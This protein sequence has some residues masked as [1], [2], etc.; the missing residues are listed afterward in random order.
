MMKFF[1]AHHKDFD[2][3]NRVTGQLYAD[4]ENR[5]YLFK[6]QDKWHISDTLGPRLLVDD[7]SWSTQYYTKNNRNYWGGYLW[8]TGSEYVISSK[9]GFGVSEEWVRVYDDDDNYLPD[10]SYWSGDAWW[11]CSTLEG[12]YIPRGRHRD[13]TGMD[14]TVALEPITGHRSDTLLGVYQELDE[15]GEVNPSGSTITIGLPM[16]IDQNSGVYIRSKTKNSNG[17][18]HYDSIHHDGEG[19][20][21]GARDSVNGWW[22]GNE[23]NVLSAVTF[24]FHKL[25]D[26]EIEDQ[27]NLTIT[28]DKLVSGDLTE[29]INL[30]EVSQWEG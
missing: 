28:Y 3:D 5:K 9:L 21:I 19:W 23:P 1:R 8:W 17:H 20:I 25:P 11:S 13:K 18:Y 15:S 7:S 30:Y 24:T 16:F 22:E 6:Y 10:D 26:S 4:P 2:P 12:T 29:P 14:K 27:D